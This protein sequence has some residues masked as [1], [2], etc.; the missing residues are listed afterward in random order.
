MWVSNK[1]KHRNNL[2]YLLPGMGRG[3]RQRFWRNMAIGVLVGLLMAGLMA[4]F[5]WFYYTR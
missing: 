4:W 5:F 3:S 2:Y 1:G